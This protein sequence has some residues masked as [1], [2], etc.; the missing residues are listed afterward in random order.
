MKDVRYFKYGNKK[1]PF[2]LS[3]K[4]MKWFKQDTG[5]DGIT[6]DSTDEHIE[7]YYYYGFKAGYDAINKEC[8]I[9]P[10]DMEDILD[11]IFP[12]LTEVMKSFFLSKEKE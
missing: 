2:R 5:V 8:V 11:E 6:E 7:L 9:K 10:E 4:A 3:Y 1:L 12:E